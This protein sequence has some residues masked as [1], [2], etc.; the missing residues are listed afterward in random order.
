M[1]AFCRT[2]MVVEGH[3]EVEFLTCMVA[4]RRRRRSPSSISPW[5]GDGRSIGPLLRSRTVEGRPWSLPVPCSGWRLYM[6]WTAKK[7]VSGLI[8]GAPSLYTAHLTRSS[9]TEWVREGK[10]TRLE[11][12]GGYSRTW[13]LMPVNLD[14]LCSRSNFS[15]PEHL[16]AFP[17][18]GTEKN[19]LVI[20]LLE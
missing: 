7:T 13:I 1:I 6:W 14:F 15:T 18:L 11:T 4:T 10:E 9:N 20:I 12:P 17:I 5:W 8:G 2:G 3:G 16:C 19:C